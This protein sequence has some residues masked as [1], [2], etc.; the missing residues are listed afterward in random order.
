MTGIDGTMMVVSML[1]FVFVGMAH[2]GPVD[3][4]EGEPGRWGFRPGRDEACAMNPPNLSWRPQEDAV[5]Y[6]I[7]IAAADSFSAPVY[8]AKDIVFNVHTPTETLDPGPYFW[9]FLFS[10]SEGQSD[11]SQARSFS[12]AEGAVEMPLPPKAELMDRI[13]KSHPR[14]FIRPEDMAD[15]RVRKNGD[16]SRHY[17]VLIKECD[18]LLAEQ[19]SVEEPLLYDDDMVRGSDQW[20]EV[21]WGNRRYTQKVLNGA[22]TLAFTWQLD[23]NE[24]YAAESKRILLACAEW[25]PK[26]AAGY[27][28]NDEAGMP[29]NY[30]FCRTYTYLYDYLSEE[31]RDVCR[32]LMKI[33]GDEMNDHLNPGHLWRP[34]GSHA[35]RAWHFLGEIGI[36][37]LGEV[38]GAEEWIW[39][40]MNVF[41]NTYPVWNDD[42]G[43]W[44]EGTAYWNSYQH[45]FT[46]WADIMRAA[47]GINAFDKPYYSKV[48]YYAMYL[49]PPG[50]VGGGFGDLTAH[51][52]SEDNVN[53]VR[54]LAAQAGN[55]HWQWYVDVHEKE[56]RPHGYVDYIR[57]ALPKAEPQAP[58][59]LP[60][61][62]L[63]KGVGQA[64]LNTNLLDAKDNVEVVF[65]SSPFGTQSHGYDS[66]N[67]F[68]LYAFGERL[69][70]RTGRR[71]SYGSEHH[72]EWMWHTK[73]VNSITVDGEGQGKRTADAIGEVT[74]F[75]TSEMIDYVEGEAGQ[76]YEG[77]L[78]RFTRRILFL[79]PDVIVVYDVVKAP[80][81]SSFEWR[82]HAPTEM[83]LDG[84]SARVVAGKAACDV[85]FLW[86]Q[87]LSMS[88]TDRFDT[89]PRPRIKLVEYHLTNTPEEKVESQTFV[90]VI[91]PY[92]SGDAA[93]ATIEKAESIGG[94]YGLVMGTTVGRATIL[95]Q[96]NGGGAL[97]WEGMETENSISVSVVREGEEVARFEH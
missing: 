57:G 36:T 32:R 35:N 90:T 77:K 30:F 13:P 8:E 85:D 18:E 97:S 61:S 19:L 33:R 28:Y 62:R 76:A 54:I 20:R 88:Q 50:T 43:G 5:T 83:V 81:P 41:A 38:E 10:T 2:A 26:G 3:E 1:L 86:P 64:Y 73:S 44:H 4:R 27:R 40:A 42:D 56:D 95:L 7:Q 82:L 24:A 91:R 69:L 68:L 93:T 29:Y 71:D 72:K 96:E 80:A 14:L 60:S 39:F 92:R 65:K 75:H 9:R 63:F 66:N 48:G 74:G 23:G 46:W 53:L 25:D 94:G 22:A 34:F 12:I 58:D 45:R 55:P 17:A 49:Q 16:L 21:W 15:L 6:Q 84:S 31:E 78:D 47:T 37:F 79:K 70:I 51:R 11:W 87:N 59:D 67:A 89:P 52:E